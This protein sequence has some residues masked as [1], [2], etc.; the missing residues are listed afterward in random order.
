MDTVKSRITSS[1]PEVITCLPEA[2]VPFDGAKAWIMQGN[3]NQIVFF[4]FEEGIDLPEHSH[5]YPQWGIVIEGKM[6]L[7]I[8]GKPRICQKGDE[9][10]IPIL[11]KH[12]AK[13][14]K[15]TRVMDFFS[16]KARY[17]PKKDS[18][19]KV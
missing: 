5:S 4:E 15:P 14:L 10:L 19:E 2:E 11:T 1:Y 13:F 9:Y 7:K 3:L 6:E 8:D 18:S 12:C 17:N 16:E